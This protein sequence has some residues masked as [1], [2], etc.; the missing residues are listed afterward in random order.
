LISVVVAATTTLVLALSGT[1]L[2]LRS[3]LLLASAISLPATAGGLLES[4]L[5]AAIVVAS[6]VA[7]LVV[8]VC[9][10]SFHV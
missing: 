8:E 3:E 10:S 1:G 7:T 4:A 2:A 9:V 6:F 5:A